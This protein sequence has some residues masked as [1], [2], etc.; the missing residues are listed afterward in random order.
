MRV[1]NKGDGPRHWVC[2]R[3]NGSPLEIGFSDLLTA[4]PDGEVAHHHPYAEYYVVIEGFGQ[5]DIDGV[6]VPLEA[7]SVV[8]V[9][10]GERHRVA[11]VDPGGVRWIVIKERSEPN[12]KFE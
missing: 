4:V 6:A 7:D 9:E 3:W 8:M 10:P 2:G 11:S 1:F 12:T 5:L